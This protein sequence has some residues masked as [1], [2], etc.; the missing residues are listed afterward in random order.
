MMPYRLSSR[1]SVRIALL[2][3][4]L[5]CEFVQVIKELTRN[6]KSLISN[7]FMKRTLLGPTLNFKGALGKLLSRHPFE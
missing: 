2:R 6:L 4:Y 5:A 7:L 1:Y 3:K